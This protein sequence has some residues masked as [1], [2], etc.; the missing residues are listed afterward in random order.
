M[1]GVKIMKHNPLT[2]FVKGE[3]FAMND[4]PLTP[5]AKGEFI[6]ARLKGRRLRGR[7]L[8]AAFAAIAIGSVLFALPS[9]QTTSSDIDIA[10]LLPPGAMIYL[11]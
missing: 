10:T 1:R 8:I 11:E 3:C 2:P 7:W 6:A 5:F 9:L 4:N